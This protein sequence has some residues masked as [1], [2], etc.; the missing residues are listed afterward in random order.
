MFEDF[1][2]PQH[3][4]DRYRE[5]VDETVVNIKRR[6]NQDLHFT[7]VKQIVNNG[8]TKHIFTR[9]SKEF[10][11]VKVKGQWELKTVIKRT[12]KSTPSAI[13]KRKRQIAA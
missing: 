7:K 6:I 11:F 12:R 1:S 10:I 5:R 13:E 4:I 9:Y 2:I 3:I 8:R